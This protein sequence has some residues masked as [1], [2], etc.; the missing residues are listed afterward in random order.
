M[1]EA[2][3]V[4]IALEHVALVHVAAAA[5]PELIRRLRRQN[6]VVR[7]FRRPAGS[8][9]V[10]AED[11]RFHDMVWEAAGRPYLRE[12]IKIVYDHHEPARALSRRLH[13]PDQSA[14]EHE[15]VIEALARHDALSAQEALRRHRQRGLERALLA[16]KEKKEREGLPGDASRGSAA[17]A[18]RGA[19]G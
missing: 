7:Q 5:T 14:D 15:E 8:L 12:Q 1:A 18:Q 19:A 17:G 3:E 9:M 13:R 2:V 16:L 6:K 10:N 11:Y 4:L